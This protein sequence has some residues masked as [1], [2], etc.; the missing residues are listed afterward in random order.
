[1][2]PCTSPPT[3]PR[4]CLQGLCPAREE[5]PPRCRLRASA[6]LKGDA[7]RPPDSGAAPQAPRRP[8]PQSPEPPHPPPGATGQVCGEPRVPCRDVVVVRARVCV[9]DGDRSQDG[10]ATEPLMATLTVSVPLPGPGACTRQAH[11]HL[12]GFRPLPPPRPQTHLGCSGA[13]PSPPP[14]RGA[15]RPHSPHL[16]PSKPLPL[17]H[18]SESHSLP[19][20]PLPS[21]T[22]S[23]PRPPPR[24]GANGVAPH[25]SGESGLP[26][27]AGTHFCVSLLRNELFLLNAPSFLNH[28]TPYA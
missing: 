7:R 1:M 5:P 26:P 23:P 27:P 20:H 11:P 16:E 18:P 6:G 28:L 25:S 24:E 19:P 9:C 4:C 10:K 2:T 3:C 22:P 17:L 14:L 12:P 21:P 8:C 13:G 15:W